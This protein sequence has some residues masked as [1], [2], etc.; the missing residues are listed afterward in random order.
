M[1]YQKKKKQLEFHKILEYSTE[2]ATYEVPIALSRAF[3]V[4]T[5]NDNIILIYKLMSY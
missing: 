3:N 4:E 2:Q 1:E 5:I